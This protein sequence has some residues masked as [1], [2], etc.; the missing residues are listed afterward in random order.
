MWI[1]DLLYKYQFMFQIIS[2]FCYF[3]LVDSLYDLIQTVFYVGSY[4]FLLIYNYCNQ[5]IGIFP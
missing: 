2:K 4:I 5:V 3:N 1:S